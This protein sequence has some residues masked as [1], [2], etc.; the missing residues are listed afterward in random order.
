MADPE[1]L[2]VITVCLREAG[3]VRLPAA[4]GEPHR[5]LD[6]RAIL[7]TLRTLIRERGVED[8]VSVRE[9]CAGGCYGRGPNVSVEIHAS[10]PQG[11]RQDRVA[12]DWKTYVYSIGA[13]P[14]LAAIIEENLPTPLTRVAPRTPRRARASRG[15]A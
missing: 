7:D 6:A 15:P 11:H 12:I 5:R 10:A 1:R 3:T 9:G 8:R 13:L 2:L 4:P 14:S